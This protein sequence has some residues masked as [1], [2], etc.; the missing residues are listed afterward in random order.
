M[1]L[2]V[3]PNCKGKSSSYWLFGPCTVCGGSGKTTPERR[4]QVIANAKDARG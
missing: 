4:A 2:V 3:C 1:E